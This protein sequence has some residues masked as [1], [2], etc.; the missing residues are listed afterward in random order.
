[1][2]EP[3]VTLGWVVKAM[4]GNGEYGGVEVGFFQEIAQIA[5]LNA[6]YLATHLGTEMPEHVSSLPKPWA[7]VAVV[8]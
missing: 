4:I 5:T 1:M 8:P 7:A 2:A 6:F 3:P